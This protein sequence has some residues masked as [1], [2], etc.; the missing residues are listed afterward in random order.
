MQVSYPSSLFFFAILLFVLDRSLGDRVKLP[1]LRQMVKD[2]P[3]M[4]DLSKEE[5]EE[6]QLEVIA[7]R[8]QKK[9][10]ARPTNQSAAQE[11]RRQLESLNDQVSF[12]YYSFLCWFL[13]INIFPL[14]IAALSARTGAAAICFFS[15]GH[16]Q[17]TIKPNWICTK[18]ASRF[19]RDVLDKD[20]WD[21]TR[22]FEQWCCTKGRSKHVFKTPKDK[23]L[24][25]LIA[26]SPDC[27]SSMRQECCLT[28]NGSLSTY[29]TSL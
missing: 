8:E 9:L 11:Y 5:E 16:L 17:D 21:V 2:D 19:S 12:C 23:Y 15:R 22:L 4:Q 6:L 13:P 24:C 7:L 1:E 25:H 27:L 28:I 14:K 26:K 18:N 3:L 20:M 10:G 29:F